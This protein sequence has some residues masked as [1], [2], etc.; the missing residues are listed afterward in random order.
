M[1]SGKKLL[2]WIWKKWKQ[3][4]KPMEK[5]IVSLMAMRKCPID[6]S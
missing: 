4:L 2:L 6:N 3:H 1:V 5:F